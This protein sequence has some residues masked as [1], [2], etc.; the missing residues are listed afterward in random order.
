MPLPVIHIW[1]EAPFLRLLFPFMAGIVLQWHFQTD[2][3]ILWIIL[4]ISFLAVLG[5]SLIPSFEK[6]KVHF[7]GSIAFHHKDLLA[8]VCKANN[9]SLGNVFQKPIDG[10]IQFHR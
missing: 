5:F 3:R 9:I 6:Y 4:V 2:I 8:I 1:K 10:L 7:I